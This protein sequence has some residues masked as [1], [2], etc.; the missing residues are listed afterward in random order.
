M[1]WNT[2]PYFVSGRKDGDSVDGEA[3]K[4]T[5]APIPT[6]PLFV[7]CDGQDTSVVGSKD[8]N[9]LLQEAPPDVPH[10]TPA[11]ADLLLSTR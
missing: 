11:E 10:M 4:T 7:A 5:A 3:V 2:K 8:P 1:Y 9:L 6:E